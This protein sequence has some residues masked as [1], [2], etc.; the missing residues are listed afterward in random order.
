MSLSSKRTALAVLVVG[1]AV[2]TSLTG[3]AGAGAA[4]PA[5]TNSYVPYPSTA[6]GGEPSIGFD[7]ARGS[8]VYGARPRTSG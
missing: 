1:A 4:S 5:S 3:A 6:D 7:T 2:A 8:A